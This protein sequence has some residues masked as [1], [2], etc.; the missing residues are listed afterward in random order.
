MCKCKVLVLILQDILRRFSAHPCFR[1]PNDISQCKNFLCTSEG[2]CNDAEFQDVHV[3]R[4]H[5]DSIIIASTHILLTVGNSEDVLQHLLP[6]IEASDKNWAAC[7]DR[8][9]VTF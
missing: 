6:L 1:N 4:K 5:A 9:Q 2:L 3:K 7:F 8:R